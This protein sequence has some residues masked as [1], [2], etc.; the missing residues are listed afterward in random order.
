MA[1]SMSVDLAAER[2]DNVRDVQVFPGDQGD[3]GVWYQYSGGE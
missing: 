1:K 3:A 2:E